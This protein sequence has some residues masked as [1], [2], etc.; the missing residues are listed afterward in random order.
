MLEW[1]WTGVLTL[2]MCSSL[3]SMSQKKSSGL[4]YGTLCLASSSRASFTVARAFW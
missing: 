2:A 3:L 4:L 1:D